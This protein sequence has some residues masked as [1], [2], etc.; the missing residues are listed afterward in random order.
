MSE[1]IR[2]NKEEY[3]KVLYNK[4]EDR[5]YIV[6]SVVKHEFRFGSDAFWAFCSYMQSG[7]LKLK[8]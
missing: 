1:L 5:F 4:N 3:L 8:H 7:K 2:S 6:K